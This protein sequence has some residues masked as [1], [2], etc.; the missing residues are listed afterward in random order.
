MNLVLILLTIITAPIWL[1]ILFLT[2]YLPL[3]YL[4][5]CWSAVIDEVCWA[6]K[7]AQ[8]K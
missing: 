7:K 3:F 8:E 5:G 1:C 6:L 4:Y 2:V